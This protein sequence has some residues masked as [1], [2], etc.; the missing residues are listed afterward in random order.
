LCRKPLIVTF[1]MRKGEIMDIVL[2][3]IQGII[4]ILGSISLALVFCR[5]EIKWRRILLAAAVIAAFMLVL[6]NIPIIF[7][8]HL[9]AGLLMIFMLI[10][11]KTEAN[12]SLVFISVFASFFCLAA[13][14]FSLNQLFISLDI[15]HI[16]DATETSN[17]WMIMGYIQAVLMNVLAVVLQLI[18]KPRNSWKI[19]P[20][21]RNKHVV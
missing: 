20:Y 2:V 11:M 3:Y 13:I 18:L 1:S 5:V 14:E 4:E 16:E 9:I 10:I 21:K 6:R 15:L 12:K 19:K 8:I 17:V 7:G